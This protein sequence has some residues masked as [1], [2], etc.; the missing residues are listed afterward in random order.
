MSD[1]LFETQQAIVAALSNDAQVQSILGTPARVFDHVPPEAAFPYAVIGAAHVE[2]FDTLG[3]SGFAQ[4][5]ALGIWS[6]Y[7]GGKET[8]AA[9]Q[10]IY[11]ALHRA[12]LTLTTQTFLSCE[13]HSA[14]FALDDDG[15]TYT[16]TARFTVKTQED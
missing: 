9:F 13:F 2:P 15:L 10:A 1:P 11:G 16:A 12:T 14:D 4:R 5:I 6:R 3:Q 7:R 8:R